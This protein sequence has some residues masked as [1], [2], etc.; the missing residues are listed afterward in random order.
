MGV[1]IIIVGI[2]L[3]H[4]PQKQGE[5]KEKSDYLAWEVRLGT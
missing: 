1:I 3:N 4:R 2:M 5:E